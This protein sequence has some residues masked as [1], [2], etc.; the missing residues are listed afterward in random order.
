MNIAIHEMKKR[1]IFSVTIGNIQKFLH[2]LLCFLLC[3]SELYLYICVYLKFGKEIQ[4]GG[5]AVLGLNQFLEFFSHLLDGPRTCESMA[6]I[7]KPNILVT[8]GTSPSRH[9]L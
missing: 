8:I 4:C 7:A 2:K 5:L 9:V 1:G 3:L 6:Q